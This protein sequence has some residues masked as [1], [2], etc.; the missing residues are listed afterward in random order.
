MKKILFTVIV[1][2]VTAMGVYCAGNNGR[3]EENFGS[4]FFANDTSIGTTEEDSSDSGGF[5]RAG[6][7]D[8]PG[9]RPDPGGAIGVDTPFQD[10]ACVFM[11]CCLAYGIVKVSRKKKGIPL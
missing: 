7:P 11:L 3:D 6:P 4:G 2:L 9:D 8:S 1:F 5:F 10:G